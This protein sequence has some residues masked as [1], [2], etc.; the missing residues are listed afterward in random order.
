MPALI[1]LLH[2]YGL[3]IVFVNVLLAQAGVPVPAYPVLIVAG[4]LTASH[5]LSWGACLT[6]SV[7]ACLISDLGWYVAGR[8]YG[9]R[10]LALL[11]K[12]SI[13]PDYCVSHTE[14]IFSRWGP[15]SL[16]VAKFIPG[17]NTVAPP[18]SGA[19]G[20]PRSVFI[21]FSIGGA[22]LWT[23]VALALGA[24]F[25]GSIDA[26]LAALSTMG[27]TA[28]G[29]LGLLLAIFVL[30][31]YRERRRFMRELRMARIS[32]EQLREL[33]DGGKD[34]VVV[35]ARSVTARQLSA[36]I[37]GA[38]LFADDAHADAFEALDRAHPIVVYCS[39]PNEASAAAIARQLVARGFQQVRPLVGGLDAWNAAVVVSVAESG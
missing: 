3:W 26:V 24:V 12:V 15:K 23:G 7:V 10:I 33:M 37:P 13:S 1:A 8:R 22:L 4:A 20:I 36:P 29:I 6:V 38:I 39:C 30:L 21:V 25:S 11:C 28:L 35:D 14:D 2:T 5:E 27:T 19:L 34:P 18:L 16:L 17:F 32:V 31:K 9:K